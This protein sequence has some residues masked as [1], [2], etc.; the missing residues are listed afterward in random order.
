MGEKI[1]PVKKARQK[2]KRT[3]IRATGPPGVAVRSVLVKG[4]TRT[5][6]HRPVCLGAE[7]HRALSLFFSLSTL[8]LLLRSLS[9]F[10]LLV[11]LSAMV[12]L[13]CARPVFSLDK[14]K[15]RTTWNPRSQVLFPAA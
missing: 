3:I 12:L 2:A 1:F 9:C 8:P 10:R 7:L 5:A 15:P 13:N 11:L 4:G 6:P 14:N